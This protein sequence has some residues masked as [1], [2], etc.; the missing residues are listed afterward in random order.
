MAGVLD[1]LAGLNRR[2]IA[3]VNAGGER[4]PGGAPVAPVAPIAAPP[5][6]GTTDSGDAV[7][8][9]PPPV[10]GGSSGNTETPPQKPHQGT[11]LTHQQSLENS[12]WANEQQQAAQN[13][14]INDPEA[15]TNQ[16]ENARNRL[17]SLTTAHTSLLNQLGVELQRQETNKDKDEAKKDKPL[18][19]K[20]GDKQRTAVAHKG[21]QGTVEKVY[22]NGVWS[23][24]PGSFQPDPSFPNNTATP[25]RTLFTGG[26]GQAYWVDPADPTKVTRVD[27]VGGKFG[28]TTIAGETWLTNP[29]G[30]PTQLLAPAEPA[31]TVVNNTKVYTDRISGEVIARVD[32][33]DPEDRARA[34]RLDALAERTAVLG[35]EAAEQAAQPKFASAQAQYVQEAQRRQK[36]A[37]T[38]LDRLLKLQEEGQISPEQAE[39]QF[40]R[41]MGINVEGPL[42]GYERA[43]KQEQQAEE[44]ADLT[45]T[46]AEDTRVEEYNT[47]RGQLA[48][49][50]GEAGRAEATRLGERTRAPEYIADLGRV[51]NSMATGQPFSGFSPG[52][53]DVASYRKVVPNIS[54]LAD[55][56]VDRLLSRIGGP[57]TPREVNVPRQP[58]PSGDGLRSLM[59]GVRYQGALSAPPV[60]EQPLEGQG[61]IDLESQGRPGYARSVYS[62]SRFHDWPI[63]PTVPLPG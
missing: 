21:V 55:A 17:S 8:S 25:T 44:Q 48:Y 12:I 61:A 5:T 16:K 62:N 63:P 32:L 45:R 30:R 58:L 36:L 47:R 13:K 24:V 37:R 26:D 6:P 2:A 7:T 19:P 60:N 31:S 23:D 22:N 43:A 33:L 11:D 38:E 57:A 28:I 4:L 14:V 15:S 53:F 42:A 59:D 27:G 49:E 29:D 46:R 35:V 18:T 9:G 20:N 50:A 1:W 41:W 34:D 10:T 3:A 51:A 40:N 56:A 52:T 54:E 39:T